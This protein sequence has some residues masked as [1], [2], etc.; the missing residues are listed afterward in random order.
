MSA[1]PPAAWRANDARVGGDREAPSAREHAES[2]GA[3]TRHAAAVI[4]L[5]QEHARA[6]RLVVDRIR[7][8]ESRGR[9]AATVFSRRVSCVASD[10][11]TRARSPIAR[12][13]R[14]MA[15]VRIVSSARS[16]CPTGSGSQPPGP[17]R[18]SVPSTRSSSTSS[19]RSGALATAGAASPPRT[20]RSSPAHARPTPTSSAAPTTAAV[21]ARRMERARETSCGARSVALA[22]QSI[23]SSVRAHSPPP[24]RRRA[25]AGA[26]RPRRAASGARA[27]GKAAPLSPPLRRVAALKSRAPVRRDAD[28]LVG[29]PHLC[30]PVLGRAGTPGPRCVPCRPP[31]PP[32]RAF[33]RRFTTAW[34]SACALPHA[35]RRR[36]RRPA[37]A[38]RAR[39]RGA[40]A[41]SRQRGAP[42]ARRGTAPARGVRP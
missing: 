39:L 17:S 19:R 20:G 40:A 38:G 25:R 24:G 33:E 36:A 29:D 42:P 28:A 32:R 15:S 23:T 21:A 30:P 27:R 26:R 11:V 9:C 4:A 41:T 2:C 12:I 10:T 5:D 7:P 14:E 31:P 13:A 6:V 22:A 16:S 37:R 35:P 8:R 18:S 1:L 3:G 34:W